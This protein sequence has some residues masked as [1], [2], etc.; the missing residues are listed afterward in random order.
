MPPARRSGAS[1]QERTS[2]RFPREEGRGL[3]WE[4]A[5]RSQFGLLTTQP[6]DFRLTKLPLA[7]GSLGRI[8][9]QFFRRRKTYSCSSRS[10]AVCAT[11]TPRSLTSRIASTLNSR[12]NL[13][14]AVTN[15]RLHKTPL[16]GVYKTGSKTPVLCH[17]NSDR[18]LR[19]QTRPA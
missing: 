17:P 13:R 5:L 15:L 19:H 1:R 14:L 10:R 6:L 8:G 11:L 3:F 7:I 12:L 18:G 9:R 16:L 2:L 4:V